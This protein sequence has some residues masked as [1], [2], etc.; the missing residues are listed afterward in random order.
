[1]G[2]L[3]GFKILEHV[4]SEWCCL[5]PD[6]RANVKG[7]DRELL[8]LILPM[9]L[10]V[11]SIR[12]HDDCYKSDH[13]ELIDHAIQAIYGP[14]AP[15]PHLQTLTFTM[16]SK[17]AEAAQKKLQDGSDRELHNAQDL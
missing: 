16:T 15:L 7:D 12:D 9:S 14:D 13:K 11:L 4:Y 10:K 8:S 17:D 6:V 3:C 1:M 2:P 5:I